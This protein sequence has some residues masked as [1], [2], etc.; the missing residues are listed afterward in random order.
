MVLRLHHRVPRTL[1]RRPAI[2]KRFPLATSWWVGPK[3]FELDEPLVLYRGVDAAVVSLKKL[4]KLGE[5]YLEAV[6]HPKPLKMSSGEEVRYGRARH[7]YVCRQKL[8]EAD[9]VRDHDHFTG[10]FR[11]ACHRGCNAKL[12]NPKYIN[13][14]AHNWTGFDSKLVIRAMTKLSSDESGL[15]LYQQQR[16][17]EGATLQGSEARG[18][19][20]EW[21]EIA[22]VAM[23]AL[24]L[25]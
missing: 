15:Q 3:G 20:E 7:C 24:A 8:E 11:G 16:R 5:K 17:S 21:G 6:A 13:V 10:R 2:R 18:D 22:N 25:H 4:L 9:K 1:D 19:R 23:G 12:K 14:F